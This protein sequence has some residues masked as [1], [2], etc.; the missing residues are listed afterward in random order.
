MNNIEIDSV[1]LIL[2]DLYSKLRLGIKPGLERTY[3]LLDYVGNPHL[4]FKSIHVAGTNGKGSVCSMLASVMMESGYKTGLYTSPHLIKFNERIQINGKMILDDEIVYFYNLIK[5][6]AEQINATFFE[7]TTVMAFYY[8]AENNVDIAV[9]ET[10]MGGRFDSTNTLT[11]LLSVITSISLDHKDFLGNTIEEI[12]TEKAGIIKQSIPVVVGKNSNPV[13]KI[14]ENISLVQNSEIIYADSIEVENSIFYKDLTMSFDVM[15]DNKL[16]KI[17][18]PFCGNHQIDNLK[19]VLASLNQIMKFF[20]IEYDSII[21]G[22][23]NAKRNSNLKSRMEL[24]NLKPF[25]IIDGAHNIDAIKNTFETLKNCNHDIKDFEVIFTC[26]KDKEIQEILR[27]IYQF[28]N[29]ISLIQIPEERAAKIIELK[30]IA[31]YIGFT[32]IKL[33][34]SIL[35][36]LPKIKEPKKNLLILGSFYL[37]GEILTIISNL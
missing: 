28:T 1:R 14:F 26:M 27:I 35:E 22:I 17:E 8:F 36:I 29:E 2:K 34:Q 6:K 25:V 11:P 19:I 3:Q 12:A 32:K 10:G 24:L 20:N 18:S 30:E 33:Y 7:I 5:D 9:I 16:L 15:F 37:T 13:I 4:K 31:D 21:N 23:R